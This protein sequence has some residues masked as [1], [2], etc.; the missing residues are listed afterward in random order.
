MKKLLI[1]LGLIKPTEKSSYCDLPTSNTPL[2]ISHTILPKEYINHT[3]E[4]DKQHYS[5]TIINLNG[6]TAS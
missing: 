3:I 1:M 4:K 6:N 5:Q 2:R